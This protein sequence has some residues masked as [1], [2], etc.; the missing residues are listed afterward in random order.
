MKY[1]HS[2]I[3]KNIDLCN[4]QY[5]SV[6]QGFDRNVSKLSI[7]IIWR[8]NTQLRILYKISSKFYPFLPPINLL[9]SNYPRNRRLSRKKGKTYYKR[10]TL[11]GSFSNVIASLC[12][13]FARFTSVRISPFNLSHETGISHVSSKCVFRGKQAIHC[14]M[15]SKAL[16]VR[17]KNQVRHCWWTR[18][19]HVIY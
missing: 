5:K 19:I 11:L 7:W 12:I 6:G 9:K 4:V 17:T 2:S 16:R 8:K 18:E 10:L 3:N 14:K 1:I 15:E 13:N